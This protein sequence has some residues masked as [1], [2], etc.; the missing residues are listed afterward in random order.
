MTHDLQRAAR[1]L[2]R[3]RVVVVAGPG[4]LACAGLTP[5]EVRGGLW[6]RYD[7]VLCATP[8]ALIKTP[9]RAW[10]AFGVWLHQVRQASL[11]TGGPSPSHRALWSLVQA[12]LVRGVVCTT[13]D[14]LVRGM[15]CERVTEIM[16]AIDRLRCESCVWKGTVEDSFSG[17]PPQCPVCQG[18]LRPDMVLFEESLPRGP[19]A[20]AAQWVYGGGSLLV[21]GAKLTR[22]PLHRVPEEMMQEGGLTIAMGREVEPGAVR[23]VRGLWLGEEIGAVLP[24]LVDL[25]LSLKSSDSF[26]F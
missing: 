12:G 14:G 22:P 9:E 19:R 4:L 11:E 1:I 17:A 3:G 24:P 10:E 23:R 16:G 15:G 26:K 18:R 21:L 25:A 5:P 20:Q 2:A 8:G 6:D 7:P 13:T